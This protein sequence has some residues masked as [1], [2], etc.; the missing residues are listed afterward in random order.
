MRASKL[1]QIF[2]ARRPWTWLGSHPATFRYVV[3]LQFCERRHIYPQST[4]QVGRLL[5]NGSTGV[6]VVYD[7]RVDSARTV[8]GRVYT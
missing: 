3:Y 2:D 6:K 8:C 1:R 4:G 5:T 7:C